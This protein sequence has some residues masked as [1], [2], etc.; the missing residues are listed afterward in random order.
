MNLISDYKPTNFIY[1]EYD[2]FITVF[3]PQI[4]KASG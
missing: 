3:D 4:V 1:G 2:V